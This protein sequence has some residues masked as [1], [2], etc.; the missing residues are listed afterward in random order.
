MYFS[1]ATLIQSIFRGYRVRRRLQQLSAAAS[2]IQAYVR[3]HLARMRCRRL[4]S[5]QKQLARHEN[6]LSRIQTR[7]SKRERELCLLKNTHSDK[8]AQVTNAWRNNAATQIQRVFK[9]YRVRARFLAYLASSKTKK[10][11]KRLVMFDDEDESNLEANG[12]IA[13]A[14]FVATSEESDIALAREQVIDTLCKDRSVGPAARE[15]ESAATLMA[16]LSNAKRLLDHY[17][18][19]VFEEDFSDKALKYA[20][21]DVSLGCRTLRIRTA[22][23]IEAL[24]A[25]GDSLEEPS[26]LIFSKTLLPPHR[27]AMAR[28]QHLTSIK[29]GKMRWW[30]FNLEGYSAFNEIMDLTEEDIDASERVY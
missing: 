29:D 15:K 9:G 21:Q 5:T 18:D 30:E 27:K 2:R 22:A 28:R 26:D 17:Y 25:C 1:Q 7:V 8:T 13:A 10:S 3:G 23:Y 11:E 14:E 24:Q 4:R 12:F 19:A 6:R 16:S 20:P